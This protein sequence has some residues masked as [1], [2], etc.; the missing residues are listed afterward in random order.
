MVKF[1]EV[2]IPTPSKKEVEK[3]LEKWDNLE[4]YVLQENSLNKLFF[5]LIPENKIIEDILIKASTLNDFYSTHIFSIFSVANHILSLDIDIRLNNGDPTLVD[6][7]ANITID[8]KK[9]RFYSFA[10]KYC[11]H[12]RPYDYPIYDNYVD[13]ILWYFKKRDN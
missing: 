13:K 8:G 11:S 4:N 6:D 1:D 5:D 2:N 10:S 9:I 3:Y 12:H 7:I